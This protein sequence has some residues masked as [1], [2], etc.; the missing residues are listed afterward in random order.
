MNRMGLT[1]SGGG[2]I[3]TTCTDLNTDFALR[4]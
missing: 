2:A 4:D 1:Q 3:G